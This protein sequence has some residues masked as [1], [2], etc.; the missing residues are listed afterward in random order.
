MLQSA[1]WK[2]FLLW[3]VLV[4][5]LLLVLPSLLPAR[6][7]AGLPGWLAAHRLVP[8]LD[9]TGGSRLVLEVSR[10]DIAADRLR[11]AVDTIGNALRAARVPYSDLNGADG[12]IEVTVTAPDRIDAARQTLTGLGLGALGEPEGGRFR[13]ALPA[14]AVDEFISEASLGAV[15]AVRRRV[16]S[17]GIPSLLVA[18]GEHDRI[19]VSM[20]G[21]TDPQRVKDMLATVGRL[22]ARI[23][24]DIEDLK[25]FGHDWSRAFLRELA[26][27]G[28]GVLARDWRRR[29]VTVTKTP[30]GTDVQVPVYA[31]VRTADGFA[32]VRLADMDRAQLVAHRER[33][34]AQRNTLSKEI[35]YLDQM[36]E[37]MADPSVATFRQ[38]RE[39]LAA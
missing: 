16:E 13:I 23:V 12:T 35:A 36:I 30:K 5:S 24:D 9:L 28:A 27:K 2:T 6:I 20:P 4:A 19:V 14:A 3:L 26:I 22:S 7:A 39:V 11:A 33:L 31:A 32:Q 8:G 18:R 38:A 25:R 34:S 17:L 10:T 29:Q 21:L 15:D 37:V 1:R